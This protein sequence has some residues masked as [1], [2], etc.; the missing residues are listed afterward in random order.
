M[1][2]M[3][4][5]A[6]MK[7]VAYTIGP[8]SDLHAS[9]ATAVQRAIDAIPPDKHVAGILVA[10]EA[11][12]NLVIAGRSSSGALQAQAWVGKSGWDGPLREGL[13]V[14]AQVAVVF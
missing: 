9:I 7:G 3:I 6:L 10:T 2:D 12:A 13:S 4:P 11:G 5:H 14:G 8:P 1:S